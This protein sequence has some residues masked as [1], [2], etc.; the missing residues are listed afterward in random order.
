MVTQKSAPK[1]AAIGARKIPKPDINASKDAA[2]WMISHGTMIQPPV[3]VA[4]MAKT[5]V[6][7]RGIVHVIDGL[8][9]TSTTDVDILW[10]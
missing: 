8:V 2:E 4:I 9:L 10:E 3:I 5:Y 7:K 6:S 1:I